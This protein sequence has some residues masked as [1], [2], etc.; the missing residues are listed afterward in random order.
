[1]V[2]HL[3]PRLYM[4][5][6]VLNIAI[7]ADIQAIALHTAIGIINIAIAVFGTMANGL[8][9][10]AYYRNP[11]LRN[12]QNTIF[13]ILAIADVSVT[14]LVQPIY[15]AAIFN[16]SLGRGSCFFWDV[17]TVLS[18]LFV[19]FSLMTIVILSL[20]SYI[21]LAYPYHYQSIIKK[22]R[23]I[24]AT[25]FS[26]F[27]VLSVSFGVLWHRYFLIYGSP[28]I[29]ILAITIVI[30]TWCWTYKL[31]ARHQRAIQKTQTP[32]TSQSIPQRRV[33]RSTITAF[34]IILCLLT[35]Y[36]LILCL[37][38]SGTLVN[39]AKLDHG[40]YATL[41]LTALTLVYLNSLLD[42]CLVF[43]RSTSFRETLKNMSI[44]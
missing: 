39:S 12:T 44:C 26:F 27:L 41:W 8:V 22:S 33:L 17:Y 14:A 6:K 19:K 24:K 20:Q 21:T 31:I 16:I 43:W 28:A 5:C 3:E 25:V 34:A 10:M 40:T 18:M 30:F 15:I 4:T 42:P 36:A 9:I 35:S 1:M 7:D 38:L 2:Q 13:L 37:H 32:S 29:S 11:R 23:L